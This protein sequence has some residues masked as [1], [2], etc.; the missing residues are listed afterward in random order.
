MTEITEI[1]TEELLQDMQD[2][3]EDINA[4]KLAAKNGV[5]AELAV[6]I[7]ERIRGNLAIVKKIQIELNRRR[8]LGLQ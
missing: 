4:C 5:M 2:S 6:T 1:P 7:E 8:M 3:L